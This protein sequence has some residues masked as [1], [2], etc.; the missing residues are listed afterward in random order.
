[1][2]TKLTVSVDRDLVPRAKRSARR[3]GVSLS[4]VI[5]QALT[6]LAEED[7]PSFAETWKGRFAARVDADRDP[8]A[9]ELARKYLG[10][11]RP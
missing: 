2:K 9:R 6:R 3:R 4:A 10:P 1:V 5:E 8:R 11:P 7:R